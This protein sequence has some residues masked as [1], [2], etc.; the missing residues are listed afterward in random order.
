MAMRKS[1]S[2]PGLSTMGKVSSLMRRSISTNAF[3]EQVQ[4][5]PLPSNPLEQIGFN[6]LL[7][8][9]PATTYECVI[10]YQTLDFP[11]HLITPQ[12]KNDEVSKGLAACIATP[13]EPLEPKNP[14][15]RSTIPRW[16]EICS[17]NEKIAERFHLL[18]KRIGRYREKVARDARA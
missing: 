8:A 14:V 7:K 18:R 15:F 16:L 5:L 13:A 3:S 1:Q 11:S 4:M 12:A 6:S 17:T 9:S 2:S 10:N